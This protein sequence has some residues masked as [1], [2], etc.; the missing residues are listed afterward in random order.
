MLLFDRFANVIDPDRLIGIDPQPSQHA[1][2]KTGKIFGIDH[3]IAVFI[4]PFQ[5]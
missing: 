3:A 1:A 4:E 2:G 5:H